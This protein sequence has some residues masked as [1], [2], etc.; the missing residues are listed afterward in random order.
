MKA[1]LI[2]DFLTITRQLKILLLFVIIFSFM[3]G[4][5]QSFFAVIYAAMLPV[6]ALAY[7]ERSKWNI[8]AATMPYTKRD[9][10]L[11]KYIFGYI[12]IAAS[13]LISIAASLAYPLFGGAPAE[14]GKITAVAFAGCLATLFQAINLPLMFRIGVERGRIIFMIITAALVGG[15]VALSSVFSSALTLSA[16]QLLPVI[17]I[18]AALLV[19][20]N[21]LSVL[22][23]IRLYKV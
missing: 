2:K 19:L 1:L 14:A 12:F 20:L 16:A 18:G 4:T 15:G 22:L 3:P 9:M 17:L 5:S 13:V 6:T 7:D 8:L 10:V 23:S 11:S 21:L